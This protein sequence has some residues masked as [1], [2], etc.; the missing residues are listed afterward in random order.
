MEGRPENPRSA[1]TPLPAGCASPAHPRRTGLGPEGAREA[2]QAW[3][4]PLAQADACSPPALL[5]LPPPPGRP[6]L[7]PPARQRPQEASPRKGSIPGTRGAAYPAGRLRRPGRAPPPVPPAH[8]RR[9][10]RRGPDPRVWPRTAALAGLKARLRSPPNPEDHRE[11]RPPTPKPSLSLSPSGAS[12]PPPKRPLCPSA[13]PPRIC[14]MP[15]H[16]PPPLSPESFSDNRAR[17]KVQYH[18]PVF[19]DLTQFGDPPPRIAHLE[20][21]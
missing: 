17:L 12:S 19:K 15:T 6:G 2:P 20:I 11:P 10:A 13:K 4:D 3:P 1:R 7:R 9:V 14:R 5:P 18:F 8:A 21:Y 16:S